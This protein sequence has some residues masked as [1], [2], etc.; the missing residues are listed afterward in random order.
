MLTLNAQFGSTTL[1][2]LIT[3]RVGKEIKVRFGGKST[4]TDGSTIFVA[5]LPDSEDEDIRLL[6]ETSAYH[7][8]QHV[9]ELQEL[10]G[11]RKGYLAGSRTVADMIQRGFNHYGIT[12]RKDMILFKTMWNIYEDIRIDGKANTKW[13]GTTQ[14]YMKADEIIFAKT[15]AGLAK[16]DLVTQVG[17]YALYS[18]RDNFYE[19]LGYGR[20]NV[21]VDPK[22][23]KVYDA[24]LGTLEKEVSAM[25][26]AEESFAIAKKAFDIIK[27]S[28]TAPPPPP[29]PPPQPPQKNDQK[30]KG[31]PGEQGDPSEGD[32]DGEGE[33]GEGSSEDKPSKK[34]KG[35]K[36]SSEGKDDK[37]EAKDDK[38]EAKDDKSEAKDDKS[39]AK[40]DKSEAKD[41]KSEA[42][43]DKSEAKDDKSEG[44]EDKGK[45]SKPEPKPEDGEAGEK[46][47]SQ[48]QDKSEGDTEEDEDSEGGSDGT[49][50][51]ADTEGEGES[52]GESD[53]EESEEGEGDEDS[54]GEGDS[55]GESEDETEDGEDGDGGD[56]ESEDEE[57]EDEGVAGQPKSEPKAEAKPEPKSQDKSK[58][59]SSKGE[60]QGE[61]GE[62][63]A[64]GEPSEDESEPS[65]SSSFEGSAL[66][67][68]R[69]GDESVLGEHKESYDRNQEIMDL[70]NEEADDFYGVNPDVRDNI[71][72]LGK[73]QGNASS[74]KEKGKV[75][76]AGTEARIRTLLLEEKAPKVLGGLTRGKRIDSRSLHHVRDAELGKL[77]AL[78]KNRLQGTKIDT[79]VYFSMDGSG[80][81]CGPRWNTQC[82]VVAGLT[83]LLDT[84]SVKYKVV[85]WTTSRGGGNIQPENNCQRTDPITRRV[86]NEWGTRLDPRDIPAGCLGGG[87]PTVDDI[88]YGIRE[89][90]SR[91]EIRKIF[92]MLTDGEPTYGNNL[93]PAMKYGREILDQARA[94]GVKVFGFGI[95][96]SDKN[97]IMRS[98]FKDNW[99]ALAEG[100]SRDMATKIMAKIQEALHG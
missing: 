12:D 83:S 80:S 59:E 41:D 40:D 22:I 92:I 48:G 51:D 99:V 82:A 10:R 24:T 53:G 27:K 55:S 15:K 90:A 32:D 52:D 86:Y 9:A 42:K 65:D 84:C 89:L 57:S 85:E 98:L 47:D 78:W 16:A 70:L 100:A 50:D 33:Q 95:D 18:N 49:E 21:Q 37:S 96:M 94:A 97:P 75:Y 35:K 73:G 79:V 5:D 8:A 4:A 58:P 6:A 11:S 68:E 54:E 23:V 66:D 91:R 43:D 64:E 38:S 46:D 2:N 81:M 76:F 1:R 30:Q 72:P 60:Q 63:S 93:K 56:T 88:I 39:G 34:S 20:V 14:K 17:L 67:F 62:E 71:V 28:F 69:A 26:T 13:P 44:K 31:E 77:P 7:E 61:E 36:D 87:T 19:S 25:T 3:S 45:K 74:W 29:P